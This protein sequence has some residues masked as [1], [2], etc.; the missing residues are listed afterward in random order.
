MAFTHHED[1][2]NRCRA[3]APAQGTHR[4]Y[5][6]SPQKTKRHSEVET[7]TEEGCVVEY[8]GWMPPDYFNSVWPS[9]GRVFEIMH[10]PGRGEENTKPFNQGDYLCTDSHASMTCMPRLG[11]PEANK[12]LQ[13]CL[14]SYREEPSINRNRSKTPHRQKKKKLA[15]LK[16]KRRAARLTTTELTRRDAS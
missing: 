3:V 5:T 1:P 10:A 16:P 4:P 7:E 14:A 2:S 13:T 12:T 15:R 6:V 9:G 11:A 8:W